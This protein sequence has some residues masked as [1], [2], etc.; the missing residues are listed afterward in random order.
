MPNNKRKRVMTIISLTLSLLADLLPEL[1]GHQ[2]SILKLAIITEVSP[3]STRSVISDRGLNICEGKHL[4]YGEFLAAKKISSHQLEMV[5][6]ST[7]Q[8]RWSF[9]L[10]YITQCK[11][12]IIGRKSPL[13]SKN[14]A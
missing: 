6:Y 4:N 8:K 2:A 1:L 13:K 12:T 10:F 3:R 14:R 9:L 5:I 11:I 7:L